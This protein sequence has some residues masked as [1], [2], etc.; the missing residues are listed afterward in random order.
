MI[1][2]LTKLHRLV[3]ANYDANQKRRLS[4][5][6]SEDPCTK[7]AVI[8]IIRR[9]RLLNAFLIFGKTS[10]NCYDRNRSNEPIVATLTSGARR[11]SCYAFSGQLD[12]LVAIPHTETNHATK[13]TLTAD[14]HLLDCF[15]M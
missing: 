3:H 2:S 13:I 6:L 7:H 9:T 15:S 1:V 10:L 5:K 11:K 12:R 14:R 8:E 4:G